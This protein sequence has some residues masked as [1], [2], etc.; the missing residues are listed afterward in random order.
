[1]ALPETLIF[2]DLG[3]PSMRCFYRIVAVRKPKAGEW[4]VS[5]AEPMAYKARNDLTTE[6]Q[7]AAPTHLAKPATG[8]VRG[9][10]VNG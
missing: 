5:G 8:W 7:I 4:F 9:R 3:R 1:M 6:Y 10:P 2:E